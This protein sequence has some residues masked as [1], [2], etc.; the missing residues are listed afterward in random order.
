MN[1]RYRKILAA[2]EL[3][4]LEVSEYLNH[5]MPR[6][7]FE[8]EE[9]EVT[10]Y[11]LGKRISVRCWCAERPPED[12]VKRFFINGD[13][14]DYRDEAA[15]AK[16]YKFFNEPRLKGLT[17]LGAEL[18]GELGESVKRLVSS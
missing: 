17:S 18:K 3:K 13:D 2:A 16:I 10:F 11:D 14:D 9:G 4:P 1:P 12:D 5:P 15:A 6:V 8:L 7:H